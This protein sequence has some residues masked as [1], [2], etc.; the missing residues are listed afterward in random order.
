MLSCAMIFGA[1]AICVDAI[2]EIWI[3]L[4]D[5]VNVPL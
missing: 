2:D 3:A 5:D 1:H 4:T